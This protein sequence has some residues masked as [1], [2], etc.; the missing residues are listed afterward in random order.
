MFVD[1]E[2]ASCTMDYDYRFP[3]LG[4]S[5]HWKLQMRT[6]AV[7]L[8]LHLNQEVAHVSRKGVIILRVVV[9]I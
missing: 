3:G 8:C 4:I 5:H 2:Y 6:L 7:G 9:K 1:V